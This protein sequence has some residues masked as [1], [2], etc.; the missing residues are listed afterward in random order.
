MAVPTFQ[1]PPTENASNPG[2]TDRSGGFGDAAAR[3]PTVAPTAGGNQSPNMHAAA[4]ANIP[5]I[6]NNGNPRGAHNTP[7]WNGQVPGVRTTRFGGGRIGGTPLAGSVQGR[8]GVSFGSGALTE[9]QVARNEELIANFNPQQH[10]Q[11][12][13][14]MRQMLLQNPTGMP[15]LQQKPGQHPQQPTSFKPGMPLSQPAPQLPV[16]QSPFNSGMGPQA[17]QQEPMMSA[18]QGLDYNR[19]GGGVPMGYPQP[20][21]QPPQQQG[22]LYRG[23]Q[24]P[25]LGRYRPP[26]MVN[27]DWQDTGGYSYNL[28]NPFGPYPNF[29][30]GPYGYGPGGG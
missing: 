17:P 18:G 26:Q 14:R 13:E 15:M 11:T 20:S 27:G 16:P 22:P 7:A 23:G 12:M 29:G 4:Q 19:P 28:P 5:F 2:F 1:S 6:P 25:R 8:G 3:P 10:Q 9:D 30:Q 24:D 21:W